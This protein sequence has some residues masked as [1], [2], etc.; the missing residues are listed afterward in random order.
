MPRP[1]TLLPEKL[2]HKQAAFA[3]EW[4]IDQNGTKAAIRAGY[5]P[6]GADVT[7]SRLLD[8][9]RVWE[10]AQKYLAPKQERAESVARVTKEWIV[11]QAM[12]TFLAAEAAGQHS[13][14]RG[15][16]ELLAKL[17][18]HI[19]ERR[20]VRKVGNWDD[21]SDDELASLAGMPGMTVAEI[22]QLR[23]SAKGRH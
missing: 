14:A 7:A 17:H 5:S 23:A 16:L 3:R 21:L 13:A 8:D 10:A 19:I 18:G 2:T 4:A 22:A 20:D 1:I 15:T 11:E 12:N 9:P 6:N